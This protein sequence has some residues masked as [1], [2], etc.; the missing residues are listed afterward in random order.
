MNK[1]KLFLLLLFFPILTFSQVTKI[2][3][4]A[5]GAEGKTI[6][7]ST[8]ADL[9]TFVEKPLRQAVIDSTGQF[10]I[11]TELHSPRYAF[12]SIDFHK[13]E[14]F[15][16]PGK[17][18][19][20]KLAPMSYAIVS[21]MNPLIQSQNLQLQFASLDEEDLNFLIQ[22]FSVLYNNF[23]LENF[24]ALYRDRNKAKLDTFRITVTTSFLNTRNSYFANYV[25]YK[26]A[27][28]EQLAQVLSKNQIAKKYFMDAPILYDNTEYMDFF[29]QFFSKYLTVTSKEV[30][31]KD[32]PKIISTANSYPNLIKILGE[33][34]VL[35]KMQLRELVLLKGL[36]EMFD[37][38]G[39]DQESILSL[40]RTISKDSKYNENK[41]VAEDMIRFLTKL[42][43]G[44]PAPQF[45]LIDRNQKKVSLKDF[46][47]K[48]VVL[49]FWTTY[50]TGCL[51][52]MDL[53]KPLYDKYKDKVSFI[54]ISTD[55]YFVKMLF[56]I[57]LKRDFVWTFLHLGDQ[58]ELLKDYDVRTY[59]LFVIIDKNGN[60]YKYPA[61]MPSS[62]LDATLDKLVNQ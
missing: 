56:F 21:D 62:G 22:Q 36:M 49:N 58:L 5:P 14:L 52:E 16:E 15:I 57:N 45:T 4:S 31:Y 13:A 3:G 51:T 44:T 55:Q 17:T 61:D 40:L 10:V 46:L 32:L 2:I 9:I 12:L 39:Y 23:L 59:P 50:C 25:K 7:L 19:N 48:P 42:R 18:Y 41:T 33:D 30:K 38:Q 60:I 34:T 27:S 47:G 26:M 11:S 6:R 29:N 37:V 35:R 24:N 1:I 20:I 53:I 54:S 43:V 8:P 28:L